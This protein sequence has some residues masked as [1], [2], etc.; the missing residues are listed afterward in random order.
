MVAGRYA[1][2]ALAVQ[3]EP[4]AQQVASSR[5][6]A[7]AEAL[8]GRICAAAATAAR[9]ECQLLDL[10]GEFDATGAVRW[11]S[12]VKSLAHW[13]SWTCSMSPGAARERVRVAR[14]LRRMPTV[15]E[16]F[17]AG[18]LSYSK[19]RE[20]T[21][22]VDVVEE[23]RLCELALTATASQLARTIAGFRAADGSRM[24]Q[25]VRRSVSWRYREDGTLTV[26]VRLPAE[27]GAVLV[28]AITAAKGQLGAP[29]A[30]PDPSKPE[31]PADPVYSSADALLD[32][33]RG[34]LAGTPEDRS[35]EDRTLVVVHVDADQLEP[36]VPAGTPATGAPG[37]LCEVTGVGPV[38]PETARRL[39]CDGQVLGA[40]VQGGEVLALGRA[41]RLVSRGQ[42]RALMVRDRMCQFPGCSQVRHLQA[43][44]RVAWA[45][46]GATDLDNLVL[47]CRFHHT[48]V[49][50]GAMTIRPSSAAAGAVARWEFLMPDGTLHR[51]WYSAERLPHHLNDQLKDEL[52]RQRERASAALAEVTGMD[53]PDARTI[54]PGWAG[55]R[56]DL[57]ACVEVLF[58]LRLPGADEGG[59]APGGEEGEEAGV[60]A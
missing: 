24:A 10:V 17:A 3:S 38:E 9:S 37:P 1:G 45:A 60:A 31:V 33:A 21:R 35:G 30:T 48:C 46:G 29:P 56:F 41:R 15:R 47:L 19:V 52:A 12:G 34:F 13:L 53:H 50:E 18:R 28:A 23:S 7:A 43:H 55:E 27:E 59:E 25:Q 36:S 39:A 49:H 58:G 20:A 51:S 4:T 2:M 42:R 14:A 16:A 6:R 40:I 5:E 11:W 57:H 54:R 8:A 44:H 32:V 26:S 22:V